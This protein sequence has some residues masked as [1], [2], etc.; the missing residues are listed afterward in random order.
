MQIPRLSTNSPLDKILNGGIEYGAVTNLFGP[1]GFGKTNIALSTVLGCVNKVIY[2]DTE[3]S[4]SI[5]RFQQLGG[6]E[7]KM[8]Q[9]ILIEPDS[10]EKQCETMQRLGKIMSKEKVDLIVVDSM[11][12]LYRLELDQDNYQTIN[13]GLALQYSILSN[14]ARKHNIPILVT[15]QVYNKGEEIE[16]TSKTVAKYWSKC[17]VELTRGERENQRMAIIRKHRSLPE[18]GKITFEITQKGFKEVKFNIF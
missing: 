12:S 14:I 9:I 1:A 10:W 4:F 5:E 3:G 15:S 17:M 16:I 6:D 18:G 8:K 13:R 2:L 7:K 11:V